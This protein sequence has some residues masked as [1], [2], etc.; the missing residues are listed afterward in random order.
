MYLLKEDYKRNAYRDYMSSLIRL[1]AKGVGVEVE[2]TYSDVVAEVE[3]QRTT[4]RETTLAEA[5]AFWEQALEDS[6][7]MVEE[8]GG[9][10][11]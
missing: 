6:R 10:G 2:T 9:E 3:P 8:N 7:R 1:C 11:S 4:R 5:E